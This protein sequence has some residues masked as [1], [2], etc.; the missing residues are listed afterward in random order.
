[1]RVPKWMCVGLGLVGLG[2]VLVVWHSTQQNA[3][4]PELVR[5]FV[6]GIDASPM[7]LSGNDIQQLKDPW[8]AL[9][10]R[11][12]TYPDSLD[13]SLRAL[14]ELPAGSRHEKQSSYFVSES[15][16]LLTNANLTRE[17]R[18]VV[19]R[20]SAD[21]DSIIMF[22]APAGERQGFI[23]VMSWNANRKVFNFYRHTQ[24][25]GW[26][27]KG[28]SGHAIASQTRGKGCFACHV[29]GVPIMKELRLPW[30]NWHSQSARIPPEAIPSDE[31]KKSPLWVNKSQAENL[32]LLLKGWITNGIKGQA[33]RWGSTDAFESSVWLRPLF[34]PAAVNLITSDRRGAGLDQLLALPIAFFLDSKTFADVLNMDVPPLDAR[35]RRV[36]YSAALAKLEVRLEDGKGF[37]QPGD[38]HFAFLVPEPSVE[39]RQV[40]QQL[41]QR[42]VIS[43]H[44]AICVMGVDFPNP[45]YSLARSALLKYVP[46]SVAWRPGDD[47]SAQLARPILD[48]AATLPESTPE[49]QFAAHW[50]MAP[51]ALRVEL[52]KRFGEYFASV[53]R[54]LKLPSDV[55]SYCRLAASRRWRFSKSPLNEFP[56]LLPRTN[57]PESPV[58]RMSPDGSVSP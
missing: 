47:M 30:Q 23:E 45:T 34:E 54:R 3:T 42:G 4:Q 7:P 56:L 2:L 29:H 24:S 48:A 19:N 13:A 55:E 44:F 58:L 51:D 12:R 36:D 25:Q 38:T 37:S 1:M 26:L 41:I 8:G 9:V 49:A 18:M 22:S 50:R 53:E 43:R 33:D 31:I 6:E 46:A 52:S 27:W 10:L 5:R 39:D 11:Q 32:E 16:Q 15:G 14:D 57:V 21:D 35:V 28:D 40:I 17:F 20:A